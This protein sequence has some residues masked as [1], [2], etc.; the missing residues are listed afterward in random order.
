MD[1]SV[2]DFLCTAKIISSSKQMALYQKWLD[3]SLKLGPKLDGSLLFLSIQRAGRL[4]MLIRCMEDER[5]LFLEGKKDDN[6]LIHYSEN[7][8]FFSELWVGHIYE[9]FRV[10]QDPTGNIKFKDDK[11]I[12]LDLELLRMPLE[13]Y[14]I[15]K[16][17]HLNEE[18]TLVKQ[19]SNGDE[20][21]IVRY[22]KN[23]P[24][25][26]HIMPW[27]ISERGSMMWHVID[28]RKN[29]SYWIERRDISDRIVSLLDDLNKKA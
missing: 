25:R 7:L 16:D 18:L 9:I 4:D 14:Q 8:S 23:D 21:D 24:Q 27:N 13:K 5:G 22:T 20:R 29:T 11:N 1:L 10:L 15:A 3:V 2:S 17:S 28:I 6:F 19:P 26:S 12:F